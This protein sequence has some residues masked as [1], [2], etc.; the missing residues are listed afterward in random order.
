[1][2]P[3]GRVLTIDTTWQGPRGDR[4]TKTVYVRS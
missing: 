1:V 2:S 3:D 4:T